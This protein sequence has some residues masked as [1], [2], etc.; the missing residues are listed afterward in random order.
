[1]INYK[2]LKA[3]RLNKKRLKNIYNTFYN[4]ENQ[5]VLDL[6]NYFI[7]LKPIFDYSIINSLKDL[8]I[9]SSWKAH[10][11]IPTSKKWHRPKTDFGVF[12][13]RKVN[14]ALNGIDGHFIS[15][16]F[17]NIFLENCFYFLERENWSVNKDF[18][19]NVIQRKNIENLKLND[20]KHVK[21]SNFHTNDLL[22]LFF[23]KLWLSFLLKEKIENEVFTLSIFLDK[24][25]LMYSEKRKKHKFDFEEINLLIEVFKDNIYELVYKNS[26]KKIKKIKLKNLK[27]I[28]YFYKSKKCKC[29][30]KL[31]F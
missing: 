18:L 28:I 20:Y 16:Y 30:C 27:E 29:K 15:D 22:V 8:M 7:I 5:K 24:D 6:D 3:Y 25:H 14:L 31:H 2:F 1:M 4:F 11:K 9:N 23:V 19:E 21:I 10:L 17:W 12:S 13:K 26:V